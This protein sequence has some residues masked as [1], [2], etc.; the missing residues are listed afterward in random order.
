VYAKPL[1]SKETVPEW[2]SR[3]D[4]WGMALGEY[5]NDLEGDIRVLSREVGDMLPMLE[6]W[7]KRRTDPRLWENLIADS[8]AA[9]Q[10]KMGEDDR[11]ADLAQQ[12]IEKMG[13]ESDPS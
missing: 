11:Q 8:R 7:R 1:H 10:A 5:H 12:R 6:V 2:V 3:L 9:L 13:R 4:R